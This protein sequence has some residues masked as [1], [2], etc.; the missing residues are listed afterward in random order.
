LWNL[1]WHIGAS[2]CHRKNIPKSK[3]NKK[4]HSFR[5][6]MCVINFHGK[7]IF[8][9][10]CKKISNSKPLSIKFVFLHTTQKYPFFHDI[11]LKPLVKFR[12]KNYHSYRIRHTENKSYSSPKFH[13]PLSRSPRQATVTRAPLESAGQIP[14]PSCGDAVRRWRR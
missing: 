13:F 14:S 6:S 3:K 2:S 8:C 4:M 1:I 7:H 12:K 9:V 10:F 5:H 11:T